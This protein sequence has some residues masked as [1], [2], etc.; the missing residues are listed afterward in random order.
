MEMDKV[1]G[2]IV[3]EMTEGN[4]SN[5]FGESRNCNIDLMKIVA[6]IAVVGIHTFPRDLS[7]ITALLYYLCGFAVPVFF[8][9][10]GY[11][12][13]NRGPVTIRYS[14][15][16]C[17]GIVRVVICWNIII[18]GCKTVRALV[19]QRNFVEE[20]INFPLECLK[21]IF[22]E[23]TIWQFWY[24]GALLILYL[25]LPILSRF[26]KRKLLF[27]VGA[28]VIAVILELI[29]FYLR[30]PVQKYIVQTLR[31]W[32]WIFYWLLGSEIS[33]I[34]K[35]I[36]KHISIKSHIFL[37]GICTIFNLSYQMIVGTYL[38]TESGKR[39]HAEY[40]YDSLCE[41][42]W[43]ILLFTLVLRLTLSNTVEKYVYKIAP[44]AMGIYIIHPFV[45]RTLKKIV[46]ID[47]LV[48]ALV[49]GLVTLI[50]SYS[51][52]LLISK[53]KYGRYLIKI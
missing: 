20:L 24:L 22:Q 11:F 41:M 14:M 1:R 38:I 35:W 43:I 34:Q 47:S 23:G 45:I 5:S 50:I 52:A 28:G 36:S 8:M 40:F 49:C 30:Y 39:L 12:L 18:S 53:I 3:K 32:T 21:S 51:T 33:E 4:C 19:L 15:K 10:S 31:L 2:S 27:L 9:S 16:K 13:L 42:I 44:L 7:E 6:C 48:M 46:G 37:F 17:I 25:L 26:T 29:S